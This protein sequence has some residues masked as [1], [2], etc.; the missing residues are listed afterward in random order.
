MESPWLLHQ[1]RP[2]MREI[3][4]GPVLALLGQ[5]AYDALLAAVVAGTTDADQNKVL[6]HARPAILYG[7][8]ADQ[9]VPRSLN[10]N[11]N[12]VWTFKMTSSGSGVSGGEDPA[13]PERMDGLVRHYAQKSRQYL[14]AL[15]ALVVPEPPP[16]HRRVNGDG[17]IMNFG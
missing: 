2:A 11:E 9:I 16:S 4:T 1:L 3:Q 7:A 12:G 5:T 13:S 8:L 14:E 17:G 6:E 10:M 15:R